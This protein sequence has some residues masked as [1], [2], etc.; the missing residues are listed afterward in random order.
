MLAGG[1]TGGAPRP[2]LATVLVPVAVALAVEVVGLEDPIVV[3][4]RR[5]LPVTATLFGGTAGAPSF[6]AAGELGDEVV[7]G[8]TASAV[9]GRGASE[10]G[11]LGDSV[12]ESAIAR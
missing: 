10:V 1:R 2:R 6:F 9:D 7:A 12:A 3:G 5:A 4:G 8:L 11:G